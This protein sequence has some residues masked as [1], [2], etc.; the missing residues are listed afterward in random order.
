VR[1][2]V[3]DNTFRLLEE[4]GRGGFGAVFRAVRMGAE[5][6][7]P[8]AIKL[9]NKNPGVKSE[10][11][12]RFQREAVLM[13]QLVHPGVVTVYELG[14]EMGC[15]YIVME[16]VAGQNLRE[17]VKVRGGRLPLTDILE[18]LVQ[19]A[20]ALEYVHG[21]NIVHR[22]IKPQNILVADAQGNA[23][24]GDRDRQ[25]VKIVDF[26]V[27]RLGD[28]SKEVAPNPSGG[29]PGA[30]LGTPV[31][32]PGGSPGEVVGTY[33]YMPPEATGL[34][35]WPVD[36]RSDVYSLGVVAYELLAGKTP[37]HD[38]KPHETMRA[39]VETPPPALRSVRGHDVPRI[40]EEIVRKCIEKRPEN[41]YQSMFALVCDLRRLQTSLRNVGTLEEFEL[42]SKDIGLGTLFNRVYVGRHELTESVFQFVM[43]H[44]G[45]RASRLSWGMLRGGVGVGK[46]RVMQEVRSRLEHTDLHHISLRFSE[47][48]QRL[49]FQALS[50]CLNDHLM[51]MERY[52]PVRHRTLTEAVRRRLGEEGVLAL[53]GLL[54][55]LRSL[56]SHLPAESRVPRPLSHESVAEEAP[57]TEL[58][59]LEAS[60]DARRYAAPNARMNQAFLEFITSI[61]Q[62]SG[63]FV[64]L[65][66]D[67]HLADSST[68]ALLQFMAEQVN[69]PVGF[70]I[71]MTM[72]DKLPR[73]NLVLEGF[74]RRVGG[75]R[76]RFQC[77]DLGSLDECGVAE[78]LIEM[79]CLAPSREFVSFVIGKTSGTPL[80][81]HAL[82]KLM[83]AQ[84]ALLVRRDPSLPRG[85]E[86][87]VDW[88]VVPEMDNGLVNIEM[89]ISQVEALD[90]RD[91]R[92]LRIAAVSHEA[93][94]FEK[95]T[96][97]SPSCLGATRFP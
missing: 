83:L 33:S 81:L 18:I 60:P 84:N 78:F 73:S 59:A 26:G 6:S 16:Y 28:V 17:H 14:E 11:Y 10:E 61:A 23:R 20:E 53:A 38:L 56:V 52:D 88:D 50:L 67:V 3:L 86:L 63:H 1:E 25:Q 62:E 74:L 29:P 42:A 70:T 82:L 22:D 45:S 64:F 94:E 91:M 65:L 43:R 24:Y 80:Q 37:F 69:E 21:H 68:L 97:V 15:Y 71:L 75:L 39:H 44:V 57:D 55:A 8:V 13:S 93:C 5:G 4:I 32:A 9:L 34:V 40:L 76:R 27:A 46:S 30:P 19:A 31:A 36:A 12:L 90:N 51:H 92:L 54:P 96:G 48:E 79:G 85:Y 35:D 77:W 87:F 49:P 2:T 72:R 95:G 47:S 41:R 66:D 7:G 89:I 58:G